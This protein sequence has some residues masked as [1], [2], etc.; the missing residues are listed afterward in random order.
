[1]ARHYSDLGS[2]S[3]WS[4]RKGNL[5]QPIR[6]SNQVLVTRHQ[7]GISVLVLQESFLGEMSVLAAQCWLFTNAKYVPR[8]SKQ[9]CIGMTEKKKRA[10]ITGHG[11]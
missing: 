5:L 9:Q 10:G 3:N 7:Y 6:S 11:S 2:N 4:C 1:M 8:T